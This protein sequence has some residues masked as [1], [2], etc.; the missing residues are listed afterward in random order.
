MSENSK[1]RVRD[2]FSTKQMAIRF[3]NELSRLEEAPRKPVIDMMVWL[4]NKALRTVF[5]NQARIHERIRISEESASQ[6]SEE[7]V[8]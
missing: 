7:E 8:S 2:L 4:R 5:Q 1:Q 3:E 6:H